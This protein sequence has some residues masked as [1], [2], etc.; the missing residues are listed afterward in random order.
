MFEN[1][2]KRIICR[3][4]AP[5]QKIAFEAAKGYSAGL[6]LG[7]VINDRKPLL[8]SMHETGKNLAKM[9]VAYTTTEMLLENLRGK[10]DIYNRVASG[11]VS[12]FVGSQKGK[13]SGS[14]IFGSY[15]GLA[16]SFMN[17]NGHKN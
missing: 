14:L 6:L 8:K 16:S 9:R 15:F 2:F 3:L 5:I 11:A 13:L 12:G 7:T 17:D 4:K 1:K 10:N